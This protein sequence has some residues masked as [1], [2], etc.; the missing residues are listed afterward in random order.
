MNKIFKYTALSIVA[1]LALIACDDSD[2][3]D[4]DYA[5]GEPV[6]ADFVDAAFSANNISLLQLSAADATEATIVMSRQN[7]SSAATIAIN[8]VANQ[9]SV[10]EVPSTVTFAAGAREANLTVKFPN[11][12]IGLEYDLSLSIDS[13]YLN[14]YAAGS[15]SLNFTIQRLYTYSKEYAKGVYS[16]DLFWGDAE[17]LVLLQAEENENAFCIPNWMTGTG[18]FEF[19]ILADGTIQV[20]EWVVYEHETYGDVYVL[21]LEMDGVSSFF[22]AEENTFYFALNYYCSE[23]S[24]G[25]GYETFVISSGDEESE[26]GTEESGSETAE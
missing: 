1:S 26:E 10:F 3:S 18:N 2:Y 24:F 21:N 19:E 20:V 15:L 12:T 13:A 17:E 5:P 22:N 23:G 9:D 14:P 7:T 6:A 25:Y 4:Y 8:V 16:Y 11:A